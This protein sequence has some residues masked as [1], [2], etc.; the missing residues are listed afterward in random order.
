M[1]NE[2]KD[3]SSESDTMCVDLKRAIG[4]GQI[5]YLF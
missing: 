4:S 3:D 1:V 5:N 2:S